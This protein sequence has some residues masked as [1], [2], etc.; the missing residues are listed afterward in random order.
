MLHNLM[1]G[2][3]VGRGV[4]T[5]SLWW[6]KGGKGQSSG[7]GGIDVVPAWR[8]GVEPSELYSSNRRS[9]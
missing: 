4:L 5:W 1:R 7:T 6:M 2:D 8:A 9:C 3:W